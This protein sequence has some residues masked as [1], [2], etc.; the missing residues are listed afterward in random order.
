MVVSKLF[1]LDID[2]SCVE[3]RPKH[4]VGFFCGANREKCTCRY[5]APLEEIIVTPNQ[6]GLALIPLCYM[7]NNCYA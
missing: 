2:H 3:L 1:W 4:L 6:Q 7:L 5:V